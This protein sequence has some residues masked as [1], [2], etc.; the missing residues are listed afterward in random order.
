MKRVNIQYS[1]DID[2]VPKKVCMLA[3]EAIEVHIEQVTTDSFVHE[4]DQLLK[5]NNIKG[6]IELIA[7]FRTKLSSI[8]HRMNDC[9]S[10]LFG[11]KDFVY[12]PAP[13]DNE[14]SAQQIERVTQLTNELAQQI[15][16]E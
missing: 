8:D 13:D 15:G 5:S 9:M 14:G 10:I 3:D 7:D 2:D 16:D 1:V 12:G 6:A 11:Y 4:L